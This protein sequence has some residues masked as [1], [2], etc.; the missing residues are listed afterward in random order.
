MNEFDTNKAKSLT[1]EGINKLEKLKTELEAMHK[2]IQN[3][4]GNTQYEVET[5]LRAFQAKENEIKQFL[6]ELGMLPDD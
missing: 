4:D 1:S 5:R 2:A 6:R 3:I